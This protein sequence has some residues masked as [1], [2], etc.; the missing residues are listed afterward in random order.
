MNWT[1]IAKKMCPGTPQENLESAIP[2]LYSALEER[3]LHDEEMVLYAISTIYIETW[4]HSFLPSSERPSKYSGPNFE[5]YDGRK[6]LGNT[7][8]GDGAR[9]RGRGWAQITGRANYRRIGQDI[10]V[11]LEGVPD[12]ANDTAVSAKI[13]A[14]LM[15]GWENRIRPAMWAEDYKAARQVWNAAALG[16]DEFKACIERGYKELEQ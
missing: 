7:I 2:L 16:L 3:E 13:M 15:K 6:D 1:E 11:D 5:R 10:G 4:G 12:L 8:P 14:S 9:Y